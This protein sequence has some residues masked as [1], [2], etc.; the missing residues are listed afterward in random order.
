M[1]GAEAIGT[2]L[3]PG[4]LFVPLPSFAPT[5]PAPAAATLSC[6][7]MRDFLLTTRIRR[8]RTIGKGFTSPKRLTLTDGALTHDAAKVLY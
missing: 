7:Q 4:S 8:S 5:S 3:L 6:E 2:V 1:R